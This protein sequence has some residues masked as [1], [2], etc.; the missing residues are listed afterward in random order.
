MAYK[1]WSHGLTVITSSLSFSSSCF[2]LAKIGA[3]SSFFCFNISF[4]FKNK[5]I[6][7]IFYWLCALFKLKNID[8]IGFLSS[9]L[10]LGFG[11]C[12]VHVVNSVNHFCLSLYFQWVMTVVLPLVLD[13]TSCLKF[14]R[15]AKGYSIKKSIVGRD[16]LNSGHEMVIC[17]EDEA[18]KHLS[19]I[20]T[21]S[22]F[23]VSTYCDTKN[24]RSDI[25]WCYW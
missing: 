2:T 20:W 12:V 9:I 10:C 21:F 14:K 16:Y 15:Y 3:N 24:D 13:E 8:G 18:S 25:L 11:G 7:L 6:R 23:T 5:Q 22:L 4:S 19:V 17:T 1:K